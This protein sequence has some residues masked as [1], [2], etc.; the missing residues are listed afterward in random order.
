[1]WNIQN[2]QEICNIHRPVRFWSEKVEG[3]DHLED[4]GVLE[5]IILKWILKKQDMRVWI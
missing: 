4:M 3:R 5:R 1:V 2:A